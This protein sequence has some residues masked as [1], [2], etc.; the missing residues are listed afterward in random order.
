MGKTIEGLFRGIRRC[1]KCERCRTRQLAVPGEGSARR[2]IV[3]LGEAPGKT[4]D[5]IGR[6]FVGRTGR[7][8]DKVFEEHGVN[9]DDFFITS[10]LKCYH[11]ESPQAHQI[12]ACRPWTIQQIAELRP[13]AILVM[14]LTA[15]Q[16]L[17]GISE[18][19]NE[20]V[21]WE[22]ITCVMTVHPTAAMRFPKRN[23]RFR[24]DLEQV[25][26]VAAGSVG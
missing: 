5:L 11:P 24:H 14:G 16:G 19:A 3:L 9:R 18:L 12:E 21:V 2:K 1:R 25:L 26:T 13:K 15:A 23:P 20:P 22:G 4:E 6:P 10:I 7:Y 17:L 8:L